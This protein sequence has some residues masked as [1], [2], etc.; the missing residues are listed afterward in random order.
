M[1][2]V[3]QCTLIKASRKI[4][5]CDEC[6]EIIS[7]GQSYINIFAVADGEMWKAK[8]CV[9]CNT[10]AEELYA[11][12]IKG[13]MYQ[14]EAGHSWGALYVELK[15]LLVEHYDA[16]IFKSDEWKRYKDKQLRHYTEIEVKND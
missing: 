3:Y 5:W 16:D 15:E 13:G 10:L 1:S 2:D 4:H 7:V 6:K 12:R 14:D 11:Y 9:D 8:R